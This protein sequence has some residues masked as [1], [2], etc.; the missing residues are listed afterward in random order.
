MPLK[1]TALAPVKPLPLIVTVVPAG[2]LVGVK[3]LIVGALVRVKLPL[4]VVLPAGVVTVIGPLLALLGTVALI[5]LF[6]VTV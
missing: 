3:P 4:L 1:A 2:P 6:E 5:W